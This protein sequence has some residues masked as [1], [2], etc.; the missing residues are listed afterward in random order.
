MCAYVTAVR[1]RAGSVCVYVCACADD[2]RSRVGRLYR[3]TLRSI[4]VR[5]CNFPPAK[6]P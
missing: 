4:S 5:L 6:S 2:L 1:A 3:A